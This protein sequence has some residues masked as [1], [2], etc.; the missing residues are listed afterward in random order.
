[1][2]DQEWKEVFYHVG[3]SEIAKCIPEDARFVSANAYTT[4]QKRRH[5]ECGTCSGKSKVILTDFWTDNG[6]NRK[7]MTEC[8]ACNGN[9]YIWEYKS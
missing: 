6:C 2:I 5:V 3:F 9:G 4:G 7:Q 1:M 8:P